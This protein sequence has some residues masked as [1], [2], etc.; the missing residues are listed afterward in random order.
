M[1]TI[2]VFLAMGGGAYAISL[3]K[4]SVGSR[5]LKKNSVGAAEVKDRSLGVDDLDGEV[6]GHA[7]GVTA[8]G[9]DPP[10][11]IGRV[12]KQ[13]KMSTDVE[14][15][16]YVTGTLS[17]PYVTCA[18]AS[19][20]AT[21]GVYVDNRP[22]Q[23]SGLL[24]QANAGAGDGVPA[25]TLFGVTARM[26]PGQHSVKLARTDSGAINGVGQFDVQVGAFAP[27]G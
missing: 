6:V 9:A 12:V 25:H 14:G 18:E 4:N 19:C 16:L 26:E 5:E 13:A 17:Y 1:A 11:T 2:A 27:A 15:R 3:P 23:N 20:S 7:D 22:V 24:L 8:G 10:R 21:W